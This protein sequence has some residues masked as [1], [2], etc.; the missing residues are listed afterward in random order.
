MVKAYF[1]LI[2]TSLLVDKATS[3]P[4]IYTRSIFAQVKEEPFPNTSNSSTRRGGVISTSITR[5]FLLPRLSTMSEVDNDSEIT[6]LLCSAKSLYSLETQE[7]STRGGFEDVE[8][9]RLKKW[10]LIAWDEY[11]NCE[12]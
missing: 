3:I 8:I 12:I 9:D 4:S 11:K 2:T 1:Y 10:E 5:N 6:P 7:N